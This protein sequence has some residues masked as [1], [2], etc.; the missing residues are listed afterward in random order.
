M[1]TDIYLSW[2]KKTEEDKNKQ[3]TGFSINAGD[4]GYL[5]ASIGMTK[6]NSVLRFVFPEEIWESAEEDGERFEFTEEGYKNLQI[7]GF[8]YIMSVFTGKEIEHP[9]TEKQKGYFK[10]LKGTFESLS[11]EFGGEV[12]ESSIDNFRFAVMWLNSLFSF[13]ELGLDKEKEELNPKV[14]ISW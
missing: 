9:E 13:Y 2:D 1:G 8:T 6:E 12:Q 5:R 10:E 7:L 14:C 3:M 11:K 4:S